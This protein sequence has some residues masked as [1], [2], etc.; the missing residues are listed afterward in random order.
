MNIRYVEILDLRMWFSQDSCP[1]K[2]IYI[3]YTWRW[4]CFI[5]LMYAYV[6]GSYIQSFS[7]ALANFIVIELSA[8]QA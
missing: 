8:I 4:L 1:N 6:V 3:I 7:Y 5:V 2:V